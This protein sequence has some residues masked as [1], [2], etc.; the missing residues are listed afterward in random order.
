MA[1][2]VVAGEAPPGPRLG[3]TEL[4]EAKRPRLEGDGRP[5]MMALATIDPSTGG[6]Q[7]FLRAKLGTP[8]RLVPSPF[9][10]PAWSPDGALIAFAAN[11]DGDES[12]DRIFFASADGSGARPIPGTRGGSQP[13]LSPDG[14]T[15][16]FSRTRFRSNVKPGRLYA[17]FY[18]STTTWIVDLRSGK[19]RRLTRWRDGLYNEPGSFTADG[20][21]LL[22]TKEDSN[23]EG[24]RIVHVN[25]ADGSSRE[26]LES[27]SE[28][29][30]SPDGSR[31]AF[32]GFMDPDLVEAEENHDY[33][34]VDLYV[35]RAD[36]TEVR[37]LSRSEDVLESGPSWDPSGQR[38]GY[39]QFRAD[40]SFVP[41][42][43][44]LFPAGNALM[45]VNADGSCREKILSRP[46]I[47]FY[48]T[49]WQP[50]PGREAGP[51]SC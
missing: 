30:V 35:A 15:L 34:A 22:V 48:G 28:P 32:V 17:D 13:V 39:V 14:V 23:L 3:T 4:I 16:A 21:G 37:R 42:L 31:I 24:S 41:A 36:G 33:L 19:P 10:A 2:P 25:L 46:R 50:G 5:P 26:I 7:R 47:A 6:Q 45:Q 18:S 49:A 12:G 51:I 20:S 11:D 29:A 1:T 38:I 9:Q 44:L 8:N 27:A 43:G 40:T